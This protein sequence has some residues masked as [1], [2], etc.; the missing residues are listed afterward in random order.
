MTETYDSPR[1]RKLYCRRLSDLV[2]GSPGELDSRE[3]R[4]IRELRAPTDD[5]T[6]HGDPVWIRATDA[7]TERWLRATVTL[8]ERIRRVH[9]EFDAARQRYTRRWHR[10]RL[11][12]ATARLQQDA[13]AAY[14]AFERQIAGMADRVAEQE[15]R[16]R[17]ERLQQE[18]E[19]SESRQV[20]MV[21]AR[22]GDPVWRY[23]IRRQKV[24]L[25]DQDQQERTFLDLCLDP[26]DRWRTAEVGDVTGL[27]F[28]TV[29]RVLRRLRA[30]DPYLIV[31]FQ[32]DTGR[33][34][35]EWSGADDTA[36]AWQKLTGTLI[37]LW[38][39]TPAE[40]RHQVAARSFGPSAGDRGVA[41]P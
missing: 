34:L 33:A 26:L 20:A 1:L 18:R 30:E 23:R 8:I 28:E 24:P 37:E 11:Q 25:G 10:Q 7:E 36:A 3:I 2:P 9:Q 27:T 13:R 12:A 39:R 4:R 16:L 21:R 32:L 15:E 6:E 22:R 31:L 35:R 40:E 38:P 29:N 41:S 14:Q 5:D 19:Q 17:R